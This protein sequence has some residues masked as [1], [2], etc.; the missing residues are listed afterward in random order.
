MIASR[1]ADDSEGARPP[2][3]SASGWLVCAIEVAPGSV[4]RR[5]PAASASKQAIPSGATTV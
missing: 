4:T 5:T 3:S 1:A 2:D